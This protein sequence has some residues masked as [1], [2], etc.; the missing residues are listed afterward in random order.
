[1]KKKIFQNAAS[2]RF[3]R[4]ARK[5][6]AAYNSMRKVVNIGVLS[7]CMLT[8]S[9]L[10]QSNAQSQ[11][12][13][14]QESFADEEHELEEVV[15]TST[16]AG[17]TTNQ[18]A[19]MVTVISSKEIA[20]Q[21]VNSVQDLLKNVVGLDV[22]Q[23]GSN[24]V[25]SGISVR[26]G[27]FEQTAILLNGANIS[28]P[29]T[30]HYSLS[31]PINLSDIEQIEIIQGPNSL[32]YGA[33][34]FSGGINIITK[35]D[36]DTGVYLKAEGGMHNLF[37]GEV[38]G[39][40][41]TKSS[42]HSISAGY[43]SSSGYINNSDYKLFNAL[44]QSNFNFED[45]KVNLQLGFNDKEYGA[46]TFFSAEY[47]NQYD[48]TRSI[49]AAI[50]GETTTRLKL[51]PQ[52]YWNRQY[53]T[54]HLYKEGTPNIPNWY[55]APNYH[56]TDVFGFSL[57]SSYKWK[58]G[59]TNIGG[60][61][62]NEGIFS[63]VL[64][65]PL[66]VPEG[67]YTYSDNRT[68]ISYFVE[69]T[70]MHNGFTL[71]LGVLAN[72][73]T[74]FDND[75]GFYPN[76][77]AGYWINDNYK[78]FASWNSATRMPTFTDLYYKG[79]THKGNS[80]VKPETSKS[81]ELGTRFVNHFADIY[82]TGFF[83]K[84]DNLIDW[85]KENPEDLWESR[86]LTT[87]DKIGIELNAA[88]SL[89]KLIP[90]LPYSELRIGYTFLNQD[91]EAGELISNYVLDYL[92]H[93]ITVGLNHPIYKNI[94]ADWQF[95]W[96]DRQGTY[97]KYENYVAAYETPYQSF[98]ILDLKIKWQA[99]KNLNIYVSANNLFDVSYYDLGNI[100]QPGIWVLG[101]LSY[102]ISNK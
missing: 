51:V 50:K 90:T 62:R 15:I 80:D 10:T 59:T 74:A 88:F 1:M 83:M 36:S 86:N 39:S 34:A 5:A 4:F 100:P 27:T 60:E 87:L 25:L 35:K 92:K 26:G 58:L 89:E 82:L 9:G 38:R 94:S 95:R 23:R 12:T 85:V 18:T 52:I 33:G 46:N 31:L 53:D 11:E 66:T 49:F 47:P 56:R 32:Y 45:A 42:S 91:K 40:L 78:I 20:Q 93:K 16:K 71:G 61:L 8:F 64:G 22:R 75:F 76:I 73:N 7:G 17:L 68:N 70:Y 67:K 98:C 3:K 54:F 102:T 37:N 63:S 14:V 44:Y 24:G 77:N 96:Q 48:E 72:H 84:G 19:K 6:Y 13:I 57:N 97:T 43:N 99:Y 28:N 55:K 2:Y 41:K 79:K 69:H 81:F 21:P 65:K 29:Q 30:A 101:G